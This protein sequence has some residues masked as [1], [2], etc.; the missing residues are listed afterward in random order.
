MM[1]SLMEARVKPGHDK[2][3]A[4]AFSNYAAYDPVVG[5]SGEPG[6]PFFQSRCCASICR[7]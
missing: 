2:H 3:E 1:N 4:S 6:L 7:R 5:T